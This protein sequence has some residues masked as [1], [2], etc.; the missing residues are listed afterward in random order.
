MQKTKMLFTF[1]FLISSIIALAQPTETKISNGIGFDGE[2]NMVVNPTNSRHMVVAWM[3]LGIAGTGTQITIKTRATFDGGKTWST[4]TSLPHFATKWGSADPTMAFNSS[5]KL[6]IVYIDYKSNTD[7]GGLYLFSSSNGG[8]LWNSESKI[9]SGDESPK[10]YLD[11]PWLVIDRSGG[12][13][14]GTFYVTSKPAPWIA[15]PNRPYL[16]VSSDGKNWSSIRYIDSTGYLVGNLIQAPMATPSVTADGKFMAIYPSY[17]A[18][19]NVLPQMYLATSA[20]KGATFKYNSAISNPTKAGDTNLKTGYLLLAHP[21][22][23][24][25]MIFVGL[26]GRNGDADVFVYRSNDGGKKWNTGVRVNDDT[27]GNGKLQDLA[28]ASWGKV[29]ELAVCWRDR[30]NATGKGFVQGSDCYCTVSV[31]SGKTF[32]KNMRMSA[33]NA[34][35]NNVLYQSGNDFMSCAINGDTLCAVWGDVRNNKLEIWFGSTNWKQKTNAIQKRIV[36]EDL[37][38]IKVWPVPAYN[39]L[40]VNLYSTLTNVNVE[41]TDLQGKI[42]KFIQYKNDNRINISDLENGIYLLRGN[43]LNGDFSARFVVWK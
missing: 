3:S 5:G 31:D 10:I 15:A 38:L 13:T 14:D 35:F 7:S 16:K 6:Y 34:A 24:N 30:R 18:S 37:P 40:N 41:I 19:Q 9:L 12:P 22:D 2:P 36:S 32:Q 43:T 21:K 33:N 39:E 28:W 26:E 1:A 42:V 11:R 23:A 4:P 17:V 8:L 25:A 20:S 29:G 27:L